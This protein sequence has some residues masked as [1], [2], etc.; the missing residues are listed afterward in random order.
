[1]A[2][3]GRLREGYLSFLPS[4]PGCD[5]TVATADNASCSS[6]HAREDQK[7]TD[8]LETL[9]ALLIVGKVGGQPVHHGP[10]VRVQV[11]YELVRGAVL[12]VGAVEPEPYHKG[13]DHLERQQH[14]A[15]HHALDR[16]WLQVHDDDHDAGQAEEPNGP[17]KDERKH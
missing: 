17:R 8:F 3:D 4:P 6:A 1:M 7:P 5:A 12:V 13:D 15:V 16:L 11:Q 14:A 2:K 10:H 9:V